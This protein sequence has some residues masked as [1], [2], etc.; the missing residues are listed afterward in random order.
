MTKE[1]SPASFER[2]AIQGAVDRAKKRWP[3][4]GCDA[5]DLLAHTQRLQIPLDDL[6]RF[7]DELH[8]ACACLCGDQAAS[9]VLE[10][11][12]VRRVGP[13]L[14]R[15]G[16]D[17]SFIDEVSQLLR[18][19]ILMPPEPRLATY[20]AK[21]ALLAW[22]RPVARRIGLALRRQRQRQPALEPLGPEHLVGETYEELAD[23]P[24]YCLAVDAALQHAFAQLAAQDRALLRQHYLSELNL[25]QLSNS[26]DVH[27]A[28][29]ARWLAG[30]RNGIRENVQQE[31][32]A[33]L[34]T[35]PHEIGAML[36]Q[37]QDRMHLSLN[38]LLRADESSAARNITC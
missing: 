5:N 6:E 34:K 11:D 1:P 12:Y 36:G 38:A 21:G 20:A 31:V 26:Y 33:A 30:I 18:E 10:R 24:R 27:R 32:S 3:G 9:R 15:L 13:T 19:R 8:L 37:L 7:G 23:L 4:V 14:S 17:Q 35:S 16:G 2:K 25:D 22:L 28:T 29:V